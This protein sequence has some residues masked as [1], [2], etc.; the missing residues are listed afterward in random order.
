VSRPVLG[1]AKEA[2]DVVQVKSREGW[3]GLHRMLDDES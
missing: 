1:S 2:L 3:E